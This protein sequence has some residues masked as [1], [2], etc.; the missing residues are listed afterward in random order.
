MFRF[1]KNFW[2]S[3]CFKYIY[4]YH[5]YYY[6]SKL[7][8]LLYINTMHQS[9]KYFLNAL[10]AWKNLCNQFI[11]NNKWYKIMIIITRTT[12]IVMLVKINTIKSLV[13]RFTFTTTTL[14]SKRLIQWYLTFDTRP[15]GFGPSRTKVTS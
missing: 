12:I 8:L 10:T 1:P 14:H 3:M 9:M 11:H 15:A 6:Y 2:I 13:Y 5:Y 7:I 4:Y